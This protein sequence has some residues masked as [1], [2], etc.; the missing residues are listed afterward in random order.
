MQETRHGTLQK[1]TCG[2][3]CLQARMVLGCILLSCVLGHR[4]AAYLVWAQHLQHRLQQPSIYTLH[5]CCQAI[6]Q[7]HSKL[8]ST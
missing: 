8:C 6:L 7:A 4:C 5:Q 1:L 3:V 2:Y